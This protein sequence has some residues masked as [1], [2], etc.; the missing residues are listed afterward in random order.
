MTLAV[1]KLAHTKAVSNKEFGNLVLVIALFIAYLLLFLSQ[2]Y[3]F[4]VVR[5]SV[6]PH[7]W[8]VRNH[9]SVPIGQ[10]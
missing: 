8:C 5:A 2:G 10:S 3:S 4:G 6:R 9:I 1:D 7:F